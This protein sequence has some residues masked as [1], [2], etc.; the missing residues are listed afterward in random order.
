MPAMLPFALFFAAA[1]TGSPGPAVEPPDLRVVGIAQDAKGRA[2]LAAEDGAIWTVLAFD[3]WPDGISGQRVAVVGVPG[4]ARTMPVATQG[5]DGA[6]SQGVA[7]G[8]GPD[9]TLHGA[10]W[11]RLPPAAGA[12][13]VEV[14]RGDQRW[15][16]SGEGETTTGGVP[17]AGLF[18]AVGVAQ[19]ATA[20]RAEGDGPALVLRTAGAAGE[21]GAR[22]RPESGAAV[23]LIAS[24]EGVSAE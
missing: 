22:L 15:A 13:S 14:Q 21:G 4:S 19:A 5:P 2:L 17:A 16:V 20:D 7:A 9:R 12:W 11:T 24:L 10:R 3:A 23:G 1:A 8:S 6:W 18:A